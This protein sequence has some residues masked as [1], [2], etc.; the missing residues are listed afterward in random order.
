MAG[1]TVEEF[2]H[3]LDACGY[4]IVKKTEEPR[5]QTAAPEALD[6]SDSSRYGCGLRA[7]M[8][9]YNVKS[10]RTA[11][12]LKDGVLSPAIYQAERRGRFWLDYTKADE[13][14]KARKGGKETSTQTATA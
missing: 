14:M 10:S 8:T 6:F 12:K 1:M 13:I 9:R 5:P 3:A 2:A 7:I 11:Q 4:V